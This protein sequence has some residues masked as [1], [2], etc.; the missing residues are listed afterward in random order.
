VGVG[1]TGF[2]PGR[3][4]EGEGMSSLCFPWLKSCEISSGECRCKCGRKKAG[5][6]PGLAETQIF[7]TLTVTAK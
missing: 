5:V 1:S 4:E 2:E 3:I 6:G 7:Q